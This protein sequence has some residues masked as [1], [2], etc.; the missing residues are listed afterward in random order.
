M[1][2]DFKNL[3]L[4]TINQLKDHPD[5]QDGV[6]FVTTFD[7]EPDWKVILSFVPITHP[8]ETTTH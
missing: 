8:T 2:E 1:N 7:E 6:G 3:L 4:E 5:A